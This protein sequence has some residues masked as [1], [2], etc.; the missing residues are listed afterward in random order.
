MLGTLFLSA[1]HGLTFVLYEREKEGRIPTW[2]S[3][4]LDC[5]SI[6]HDLHLH[7][8]AQLLEVRC[9]HDPG[10]LGLR[11]RYSEKALSGTLGKQ[12]LHQSLI[13][14]VF[15]RH[16]RIS[17]PS[18]FNFESQLNENETMKSLRNVAINTVASLFLLFIVYSLYLGWSHPKKVDF[19]GRYERI[20]DF[21]EIR[22]IENEN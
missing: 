5:L 13:C 16:G 20:G 7:R 1:V 14:A 4:L 3:R 10:H 6:Y 12:T 9:N 18:D 11:R 22:E 2:T 19:S 15:K 21:P 17:K 8:M